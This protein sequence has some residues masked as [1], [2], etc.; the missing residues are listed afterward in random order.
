MSTW[1]LDDVV[2]ADSKTL[3]KFIKPESVALTVT[4]PPYGNAIDYSQHVENLEKSRE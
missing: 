2:C 4:S 1:I 3:S